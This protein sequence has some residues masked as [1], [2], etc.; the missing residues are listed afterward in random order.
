MNKIIKT[1]FCLSET[2][3]RYLEDMARDI[4]IVWIYSNMFVDLPALKL[5]SQI[6]K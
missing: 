5:P 3:L 1:Y 2:S 6:H 4:G